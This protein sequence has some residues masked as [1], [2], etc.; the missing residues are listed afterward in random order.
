MKAI[1]ESKAIV[2]LTVFFLTFG[3]FNLS[4]DVKPAKALFGV[5]DIVYDPAVW[6]ESMLDY[7]ETAA[8]TLQNELDY[9]Q[10][11]LQSYEAIKSTIELITQTANQLRMIA[12]QIES[13]KN[14]GEQIYNQVE[15]I[16]RFDQMLEEWYK[17][18]MKLEGEDFFGFVE[19]LSEVLTDIER[20]IIGESR[21]YVREYENV[22][23][24]YDE[25]FDTFDAENPMT[26]EQAIAKEGEWNELL[27]NTSYDTTK[28]AEILSNS[29][30]DAEQIGE[31]M[32]QIASAEGT[33][34]VLQG[35]SGLEV[36]QARQAAELRYLMVTMNQQLGVQ[37]AVEASEREQARRDF[38]RFY[39][40]STKYTEIGGLTLEELGA[41]EL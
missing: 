14:Q 4:Y 41:R 9:V 6:L 26:P 12:N 40:D 18:L 39:E 37:A 29:R 8:Q 24:N 34:G 35:M 33:V 25:T 7:M 2:F 15:S 16:V 19:G 22:Q 21:G 36:V 30:I 38:S 13:I 10:Q 31:A 27:I 23:E 3:S 28:S 11:T 17:D 5:G 20:E 1:M 32:G